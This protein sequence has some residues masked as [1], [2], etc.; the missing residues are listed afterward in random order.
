MKQNV[1]DWAMR[2][3][4]PGDYH[5]VRESQRRG[6]LQVWW[7]DLRTLREW[8]RRAGWPAPS[9]GFE[10][11]FLAKML[12]NAPNFDL[13]AGGSAVEIRIPT[14]EHT[15]EAQELSELDALYTERPTGA[16][17]P[18]WGLLV[19]EL[20]QI[21][22][23]VEAGV[24][25]RVENTH[26]LRSWQEFYAWAHGRYHALEDGYDHWIGDDQS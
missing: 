9:L 11:A 15:I 14:Q 2:T 5:L 3:A 24:V 25:V 20:R 22:R 16:Q 17:P 4:R 8:A 1:P 19:E 12:E 6:A 26:T 23:A 18:G 21:R 13:A 10:A 7:P